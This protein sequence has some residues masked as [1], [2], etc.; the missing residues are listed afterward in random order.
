MSSRRSWK[1]PAGSSGSA[2]LPMA[3]RRDILLIYKEILANIVR[4]ADAKHV[5]IRTSIR[6]GRFL[7]TVSDDGRGFDSS[8]KHSGNGLAS[9]QR[10]A[11]QWGATIEI[12]GVPG[13][14]TAITL[15]TKI[16]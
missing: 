16:P 9:M 5:E 1:M 7:L 4:H 2:R 11:R 15:D 12:A 10:R 6:G 14:G 13:K 8:A 3:F